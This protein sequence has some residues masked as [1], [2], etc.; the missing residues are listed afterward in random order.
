MRPKPKFWLFRKNEGHNSRKKKLPLWVVE[1]TF[2]FKSINKLKLKSTKCLI[3]LTN[4]RV[5]LLTCWSPLSKILFRSCL[6]ITSSVREIKKNLKNISTCLYYKK[7]YLSS[8]LHCA[9][10]AF[11]Y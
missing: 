7:C 3:V 10:F 9:I 4:V 2:K 5:R 6:E 8:R 1:M 11:K